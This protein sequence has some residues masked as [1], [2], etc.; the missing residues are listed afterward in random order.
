MR[1]MCVCTG[2][3][4]C[5]WVCLRMLT[6]QLLSRVRCFATPWTV[7]PQAPLSWDSPG[8][9]TGVGCHALLQGIFL[10]QGSHPCLQH[11]RQILYLS[12]TREAL[13]Q[14]YNLENHNNNSELL[15]LQSL[16]ELFTPGRRGS[17][18]SLVVSGA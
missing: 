1:V 7:A 4:V 2:T 16:G 8:R 17:L 12:V 6:A 9:N 18:A 5:V 11:Y 14:L 15:F 10:T 3:M 13:N